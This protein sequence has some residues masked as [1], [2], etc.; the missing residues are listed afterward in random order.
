MMQ[1][2]DYIAVDDCS[3]LMCKNNK[4]VTIYRKNVLY[5]RLCAN[6]L[7]SQAKL[8]LLLLIESAEDDLLQGGFVSFLFAIQCSCNGELNRVVS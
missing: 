6:P 7:L 8:C 1:V 5:K 2:V 3:L 4:T